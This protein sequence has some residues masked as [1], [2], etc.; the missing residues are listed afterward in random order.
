MV[1][2][3]VFQG[4]SHF[5]PLLVRLQFL[6]LALQGV[7]PFIYVLQQLLNLLALPLCKPQW[8]IF[9]KY[10]NYIY[11]LLT[12]IFFHYHPQ[13]K[14]RKGNVFT[15]VGVSQHALGR[16]PIRQTP[17]G[18]HWPLADSPPHPP[19]RPSGMHSCIEISVYIMLSVFRKFG[20]KTNVSNRLPN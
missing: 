7:Q 1:V 5:V 18:R 8:P 19:G 12:W 3:R 17:P 20:K 10:S 2:D 16:H 6:L 15:P 13:T 14:L 4:S 9:L 11:M